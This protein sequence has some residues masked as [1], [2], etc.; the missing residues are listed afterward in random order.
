[1]PVYRSWFFLVWP[2]PNTLCILL[3]PGLIYSF[4]DSLAVA[5]ECGLFLMYRLLFG[6][7]E[8]LLSLPTAE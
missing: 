5:D 7:L 4:N 3:L 2:P 1:M 8:I 6:F